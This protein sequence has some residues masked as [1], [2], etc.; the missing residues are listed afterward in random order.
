MIVSPQLISYFFQICIEV[1]DLSR[2]QTIDI[3]DNY[4]QD[5]NIGNINCNQF[6]KR[7][8][9][10]LCKIL[11]QAYF[12]VRDGRVNHPVLFLGLPVAGGAIDPSI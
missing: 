11:P 1:V 9:Y 10:E 8:E 4:P 7:R 5:A 6:S 2:P 12:H 3:S